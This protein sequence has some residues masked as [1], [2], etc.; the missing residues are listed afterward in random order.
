[1]FNSFWSINSPRKTAVGIVLDVSENSHG[2]VYSEVLSSCSLPTWGLLF[3]PDWSFCQIFRKQKRVLEVI[4]KSSCSA[5]VNA[6]MKYLNFHTSGLKLEREL[7]SILL[8]VALHHSNFS[9]NF[10]IRAKQRYGKMHCCGYFWWQLCFG[11]LPE[12]LL[13]NDSCKTYIYLRNLKVN[14][15]VYIA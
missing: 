9:N 10:T 13:L 14:K 4:Y 1:M 15:S 5:L 8:K 7:H 11:K 2:N 6:V 3:L 12:W